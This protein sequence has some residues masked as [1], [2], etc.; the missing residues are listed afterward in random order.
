VVSTVVRTRLWI[1]IAATLLTACATSAPAASP[2]SA[3]PRPKPSAVHVTPANIRRL[4]PAFP[5]GYELAEITIGHSPAGYWGFG[6]DFTSDPAECAGLANPVSGDTAPQGLD[7]SGAGGTIYAVVARST[8]PPV[9]DPAVLD[10]C[11]QW[12][13]AAG[14]TTASVE[15]TPAPQ[16]DGVPTVAMATAVRTIVEGG[17][18]TDSRIQTVTAYLDD[19]LA[20]VAVVTD[21]G[22]PQPAL[23]PDFAATLLVKAVAA[24]RD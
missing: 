20:F 2:V 7:G 15:L 22:A 24:L 12:S 3:P 8:P 17:V 5:P 6:G 21:P 9:L 19:Y 14:Q 11:P 16:I 13:M 23:S 10:D 1:V 18:A 4:R